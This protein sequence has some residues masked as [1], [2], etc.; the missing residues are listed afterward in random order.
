MKLLFIRHSLA[1]DMSEFRGHDFDRPL[2]RRG[3]KRAIR[4]FKVMRIIYPKVDY[5][6]ASKA[7]RAAQT[8]EVMNRYYKTKLIQTPLLYPGASYNDLKEAIADK[9]GVIAIVS[10]MPDLEEFV[11]EIMHSPNLSIKFSKPSLV[12]VD[13]KTIKGV[14]EYKRVKGLYES[15]RPKS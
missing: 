7:L 5:I 6:I 4:F 2:T 15:I 9:E 14:F 8:A 12:E 13:D 1:V 10:H 11:R 3:V